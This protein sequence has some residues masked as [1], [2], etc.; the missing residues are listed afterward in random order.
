MDAVKTW[1]TWYH[2]AGFSQATVAVPLVETTILLLA[3]T[4]CLLFRFSRTGLVLAFLFLYR[5]GWTVQVQRFTSD[6]A[7]QSAFSA[8]YLV[9]GILV[10]TFALLGM[11][12]RGGRRED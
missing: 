7:V 10:F 2:Q 12:F 9:F 4:V 6:P 5:W 3:I 1:W 11:A 8:G